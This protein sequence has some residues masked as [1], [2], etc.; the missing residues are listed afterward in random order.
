MKLQECP[1][2][3]RKPGDPL[4]RC[5]GPDAEDGV[6]GRARRH[7]AA[8]FRRDPM[9]AI[10]AVEPRAT[11]KLMTACEMP[12]MPQPY[13]F[14]HPARAGCR[15]PE[16]SSRGV[17]EPCHAHPGTF[18]ASRTLGQVV[19]V[20]ICERGHA[21]GVLNSGRFVLSG[22]SSTAGD[23]QPGITGSRAYR[24]ITRIPNYSPSRR[25]QHMARSSSPRAPR[26]EHRD[27]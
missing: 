10:F 16:P 15:T 24:M 2:A 23:H 26:E 3:F 5:P 8:H 1:G 6:R 12:A 7:E 13:S 18:P 14:P 21:C 27:H 22:F 20:E 25:R 9:Y 19:V 11:P 17:T 4:S